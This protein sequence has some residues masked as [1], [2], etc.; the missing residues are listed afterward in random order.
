MGEEEETPL[1][2]IAL[3]RGIL[4]HAA[5]HVHLT[6]HAE[7]IVCQH[8]PRVLQRDLRGIIETITET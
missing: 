6:L 1:G 7:T 2:I 3:A 8:V 5:S 4:G